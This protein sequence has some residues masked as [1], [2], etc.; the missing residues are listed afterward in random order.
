MTHK[1]QKSSP[2]VPPGVSDP[3]EDEAADAPALAAILALMSRA[4]GLDLDCYKQSTLR[5]QVWRRC[6]A[7]GLGTLEAYLAVLQA[8]A[9]ELVQLQHGLLVSVSAFFRDGEVFDVLR[10][11]LKALVAARGPEDA[12]RCGCR[13]VPPA[14]KPIRSP[15]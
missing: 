7:L 11:A 6:R 10:P 12:L 14:R 4:S 2:P 9:G 1:N 13:P 5:R 3:S 15:C 8:D